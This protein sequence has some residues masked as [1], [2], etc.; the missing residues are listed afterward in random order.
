MLFSCNWLYIQVCR[1]W[2]QSVGSCEQS[3][4]FSYAYGTFIVIH[5]WQNTHEMFLKLGVTLASLFCNK[6]QRD[7]FRLLFREFFSAVQRVTGHSL[8]FHLFMQGASELWCFIF[9]AE[10]AQMQAFGDTVLGLNDSQLSGIKTDDPL[11][12]VQHVAK[13]LIRLRCLRGLR[14]TQTPQ[15]DLNSASWRVTL[16]RV[17][18][19]VI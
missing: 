4:S 11:E 19:W 8:N 10:A 6:A 17:L 5:T 7:A 13:T 15:Y 3:W 2:Y 12:L 16:P 18:E 9:D 14:P 1:G